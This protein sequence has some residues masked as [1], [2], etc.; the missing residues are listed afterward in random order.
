MHNKM[1]NQQAS[2]KTDG[3]EP[4]TRMGT[5]V[6]KMR[7]IMNYFSIKSRLNDLTIFQL[8]SCAQQWDDELAKLARL[9]VFKCEFG[10]DKCMKTGE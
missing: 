3:Y 4:A 2:G 6:N 1:R 5:M 8:Y 10:H 7:E 9:N